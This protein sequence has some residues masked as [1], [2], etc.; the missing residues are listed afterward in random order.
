LQAEGPATARL[1]LIGL[2]RLPVARFGG[3]IAA[4]AIGR[5]SGGVETLRPG[6]A[7]VLPQGARGRALRWQQCDLVGSRRLAGIRPGR[8]GSPRL[9]ISPL[10]GNE[11][12]RGAGPPPPSAGNQISAHRRRVDQ[13]AVSPR[14]GGRGAGQRA[15]Y[16][17]ASSASSDVPA[18]WP[19]SG[20]SPSP[21]SLRPY[22][23]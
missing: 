7:A 11:P 18:A 1:L 5:A 10:N 15:A 17:S 13:A 2:S 23:S 16:T 12:G 19:T 8:L 22:R 4:Q 21:A 14:G 3:G 6:M 9:Q 20:A